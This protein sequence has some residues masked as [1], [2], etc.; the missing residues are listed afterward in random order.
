MKN[1]N[2]EFKGLKFVTE[3]DFVTIYSNY[4]MEKLT[5]RTYSDAKDGNDY[6]L[7]DV[8]KDL[9][10]G[11]LD[12]GDDEDIDFV[13]VVKQDTKRMSYDD[14]YTSDDLIY[15]EVSEGLFVCPAHEPIDLIE[16]GLGSIFDED[17]ESEERL[18]NQI[19]DYK[20]THLLYSM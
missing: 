17:E 18:N 7:Y 3:F 11:V 1:T 4:E 16:H 15:F 10:I 14:D 12:S 6:E 20:L 13:M 2:D 5:F 9:R 19:E 8:E